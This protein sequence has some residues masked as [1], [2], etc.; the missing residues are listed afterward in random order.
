MGTSE[1]IARIEGSFKQAVVSTTNEGAFPHVQVKP[2]SLSAV[3]SFCVHDNDFK[4]DFLDCLTGIDT[5]QELVVVYQLYSTTLGHRLNLKTTID[6]HS[7]RL[8]SATGFWRAAMAYELE[9]AE[10]L[11]IEFDG[12]PSPRKLLLPADWHGFPLRK[13]YVYPEEYHEVEHRRPPLRKE[14]VRP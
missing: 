12:H 3:L 6:R 14:H 1:L 11:G 13:D 9:A 5:G 8:P 2:E 4:F 10:M 7:P